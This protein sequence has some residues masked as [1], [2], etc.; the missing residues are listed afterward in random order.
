[1]NLLLWVSQSVVALLCVSGGAYKAFKPDELSK[2]VS[3]LSPGAWRA[4]GMFELICGVLLIV[5]AVASRIAL[6]TPFAASVLAVET[7]GLG[8]LYARRSLAL[9][10]SNPLVW[11]IAMAFLAAFVAYGR[12]ALMP[13]A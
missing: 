1:M 9:T 8:V 3:S 2:L 11:S 6:L 10:A 4:L 7:V 13:L 5:P 12:F